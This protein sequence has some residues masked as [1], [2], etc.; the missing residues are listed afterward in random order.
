MTDKIQKHTYFFF[1]S[2]AGIIEVLSAFLT[3][4]FKKNKQ[5]QNVVQ[6]LVLRL[7][8]T[9]IVFEKLPVTGTVRKK[10]PEKGASPRKEAHILQRSSSFLSHLK[11]KKTLLYRL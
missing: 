3:L 7:W 1:W 9:F 6:Y 11:S 5:I 4:F 2:H 8:N 10:I